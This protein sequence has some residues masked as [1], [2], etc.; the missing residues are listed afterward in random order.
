[1]MK[2]E[3]LEFCCLYVESRRMRREVCVAL[4]DGII[5]PYEIFLGKPQGKGR[6]GI[7]KLVAALPL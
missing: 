1:M 5:N 2:F 4:M 7:P 3:K 6:I